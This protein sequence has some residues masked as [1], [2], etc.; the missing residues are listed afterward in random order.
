M[1]S[2]LDNPMKATFDIST[3]EQIIEPLNAEELAQ[4]QA[5]KAATEA[6]VAEVA[7]KEA[8]RQTL[9]AKLGIT[10]DEAKLLLS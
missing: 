10:E 7:V 9:L 4:W 1:P 6:K 5:D 3:G 8:A 2:L